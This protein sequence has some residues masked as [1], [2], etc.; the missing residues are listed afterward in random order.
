METTPASV[1]R[2]TAAAFPPG[3]G[4]AADPMTLCVALL[5]AAESMPA[6]ARGTPRT[7]S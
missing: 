7:A 4:G 2:T 3:D 6:A 5:I 1:L